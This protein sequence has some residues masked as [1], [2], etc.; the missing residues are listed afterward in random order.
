[1]VTKAASQGYFS[2][3]RW[4]PDIA[5][6]EPR[7]IAV[8]LLAPEGG[9]AGLRPIPVSSFSSK[10]HEQGLLDASL[11][12][13][14]AQLA[15]P[16]FGVD[17]LHEL[18]NSLSSSLRLTEPKPVAVNTEN[19]ADT[20]NALYRSFV[21]AR[22]RGSRGLTKGV[23]LDKVVNGLRQSGWSVKRGAYIEDIIFDV[24]V[25]SGPAGAVAGGAMSVFSFAAPRKDWAPIEKD[26]GHFL[27]GVQRLGVPAWAVVQPPTDK[28]PGAQEH[29]VRVNRWLT[30]ADVRVTHPDTLTMQE[31]L[32]LH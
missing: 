8:V 13:L 16:E 5:R 1:M 24:V 21:A 4:C 31:E 27:F 17:L 30:S 18:H 23:V 10:L 11:V 26:A 9:Y 3:L 2:L 19:A 12:A 25:D 22:S 15:R 32:A 6:D 14:S 7:N 29:F 28:A 20:L